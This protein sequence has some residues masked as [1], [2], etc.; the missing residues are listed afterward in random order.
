MTSTQKHP[1]VFLSHNSADK[2]YVEKLASALQLVGCQVWFDAWKIRPGDS[3]P[4]AI[5]EGLKD[6]DVFLLIWSRHAA[7][8]R[9]VEGEMNSALTRLM[10]DPKCKLVPVVLDDAQLPPLIQHIRYADAR[11]EREPIMVAKDV[12]GIETDRE[13]RMAVQHA[14]EDAGLDIR[15]F[16]GAGVFVCCPKCGAEPDKI[17]GREWIDDEHDRRY[18][19]AECQQCGWSDASEA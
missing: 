5:N 17:R 2:P 16:W 8:S 19:G 11:N 10:N 7:A 14:I 4:S 9:W 12:L 18:I 6:F 1:H 15:E 3:I 13:L